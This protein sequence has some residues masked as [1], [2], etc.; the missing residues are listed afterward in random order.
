MIDISRAKAPLRRAAFS[1]ERGRSRASLLGALAGLAVLAGCAQQSGDAAAGGIYRFFNSDRNPGMETLESTV[2]Y[3][4]VDPSRAMVNAPQALVVLERN[5]GS[6]VEQRIVLP[7]NTAVRGDNVL[8]VRAQ[9]ASSAEL[10]R[11]DFDEISTRFGGLPSPFER[12]TESSLT[13]GSDSMGSYVYAT[14]S[15]GPS[16]VCVLVLRRIGVGARPLPRGTQALDVVMRNCV[17][18]GVEEALSPMSDR[19]LAVGGAQGTV[20]TLSPHAA[21]RS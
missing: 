1:G 8:L 21:P 12:L 17:N 3:A 6:A 13:S 18:G 2:Q 20:Y 11:L 15:A 9:T 5:L 14:E 10:T 16:A 4:V 19:A 7:N